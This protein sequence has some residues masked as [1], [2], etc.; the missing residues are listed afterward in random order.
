MSAGQARPISA[1]LARAAALV[2]VLGIILGVLGMHVTTVQ[3]IVPPTAAGP[4]ISASSPHS[5][6][7]QRPVR[8]VSKDAHLRD[9]AAQTLCAEIILCPEIGH[10]DTACVPAPG[11]SAW[12]APQPR[13]SPIQV[14]LPPLSASPGPAST[15]GP[16]PTLSELSI[17]RT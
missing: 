4:E 5:F 15:F 11:V 13:V 12:S 17:S 14:K 7:G 2:A 16:C 1:F 9:S 3:H 6:F 8:E 10:F